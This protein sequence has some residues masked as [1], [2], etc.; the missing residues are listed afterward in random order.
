MDGVLEPGEEIVV[1]LIDVDKKTG[2]F[3]LSRKVL[4]P[5]PESSVNG[6]QGQ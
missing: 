5:K 1:K 2:K 6:N 3:K 4:L